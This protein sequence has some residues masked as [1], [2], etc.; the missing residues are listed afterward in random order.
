MLHSDK[1]ICIDLGNS[2][3]KAAVFV[4]GIQHREYLLDKQHTGALIP[5]LEQEKPA[6]SILASVTDHPSVWEEYLQSNTI[7]HKL[8]H[9][10]KLNFS[11]AVS[12]PETV[13]ADR[14]AL[15]AGAVADRPGKNLLVITLGTCIT[16]NFV[17][18]AGVFLGGGISPGMEMRFRSLHDQTSRL[19]E[20]KFEDSMINWAIP[21]I[22][23]DTN[24]AI[25]SGVING[26][27]AE[28]EGII[29]SYEE[30]YEG[31]EVVLTGGNAAH[32]AG[33]LKKRIFADPNLIFKGLYVLSQ[34]NC[35]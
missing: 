33:L 18:L 30:K 22:G 9:L 16:Y 2:R 3:Y 27:V 11:M 15:V 34:L 8:S 25:L 4:Q 35:K 17:S 23:Y 5:L 6:R 7:F 12:K 19:P 10:S 21:L 32:F 13:G 20:V 26:M 31:L 1:T 24:N 14:F 28:A 29:R